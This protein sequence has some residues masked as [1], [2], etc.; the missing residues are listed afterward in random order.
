LRLCELGGQREPRE[1][2]SAIDV[3]AVRNQCERKTS[4]RRADYGRRKNRCTG[5]PCALSPRRRLG[6]RRAGKR[7]CG[8]S[9][10]CRGR[11]WWRAGDSLSGGRTRNHRCRCSLHTFLQSRRDC[12]GVRRWSSGASCPW[13]STW[14]QKIDVL[15]IIAV[16]PQTR[17]S[18]D[19]QPRTICF[20]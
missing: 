18:W 5:C 19:P 7:H 13:A 9:T 2:Y 14:A 6:R 10:G 17:W 1:R 4:F 16:N 20:V 8:P 15:P 12:E 3:G 11:R